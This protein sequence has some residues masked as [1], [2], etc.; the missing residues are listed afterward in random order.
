MSKKTP[1]ESS[2]NHDDKDPNVAKKGKKIKRLSFEKPLS[3]I[4]E[5][6]SE[7]KRL[8]AES[9][10]DLGSKIVD[11]EALA[12]KKRREIF[13]ALTPVQIV[14]IARHCDRPD[15][16]SLIQL[17]APNFIELHGDRLFRDDPSIVSGIGAING[18]RVAFVAH[19]KGHDTKENIHRNF[20]MPH[21]EGYRKALRIMKMAERFKMPIITFIDTPGAYPGIG[22]EERGQSE[23]IAKNLKEM[24][25]LKVPVISFVL[26]E[27]GSGGALGIGVSNKVYMLEYAVYSVIS[28]EGCASILFRDAA[29]ADYAADNL[30]ITA[31]DVVA[32]KVA[33]G[34]IKEPLGGAHQDWGFVASAIKTQI[35]KDLALYHSKSVTEILDERYQKFR[36]MGV[37]EENNEAS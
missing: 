34:I 19:Q 24:A 1:L 16:K 7:L 2:E 20:G 26:G 35:E 30:K 14:E 13:S 9:D 5:K 23:A 8:N 3:D 36:Q 12:E 25:G 28:P 31:P 33:D 21:P 32:L 22:A 6:I 29:K 10:I 18:E 27:G 17:I 15:S 37:F 4:I 11:Y